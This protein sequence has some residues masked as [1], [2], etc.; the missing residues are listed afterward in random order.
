MISQNVPIV[1]FAGFSGSG[2]TTLLKKIIPLLKKH[3]LRVAV[4][5]HAHHTFD[6][7]KPG[8]DSYEARSAGAQQVLVASKHRWA[9]MVET[10]EQDKDPSL[11]YL[12]G[13]IDK[14]DIDIILVEGFKRG[15]HP[16]IEI[17]RCDLEHKWL[18]P[19]D[20]NIIAIA[21]DADSPLG[22]ELPQLNLNDPE[23]ICN[24]IINRIKD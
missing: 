4:L 17:H 13:Q 24:F 10:P 22:V 3:G 16:K 6:I 20:V 7:D 23:Q 12:L 15:V 14:T 21:T 2:K 11:T 9:L 5:K 8:K 19:D 1:G 18:Y